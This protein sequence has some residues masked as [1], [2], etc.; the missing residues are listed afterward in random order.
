MFKSIYNQRYELLG[1]N[2]LCLR[3]YGIPLLGMLI[4]FAFCGYTFQQIQDTKYIIL[5]SS[6]LNVFLYWSI[7]RWSIIITRWKLN[8]PSQQLV[9]VFIQLFLGFG[10]AFL[11]A[12]IILL[13]LTPVFNHLQYFHDESILQIL[14]IPFFNCMFGAA[15]Y[16]GIYYFTRYKEAELRSKELEKSN[17]QAQLSMLKTQINPHFLFNSLNTLSYLVDEDTEK[18]Q[19]FIVQLSNVYRNII[20]LSNQKLISVQKEMDFL[21]SFIY[22]IK[23]RFGNKIAINID[24]D[25]KKLA[26]MIIP[27]SL[28]MLI[29]NAIK[30]NVISAATPLVINIISD[31]KYLI[32]SNLIKLRTTVSHSTKIGLQNIENRYKLVSNESIII[33]KEN[34]NFT[35]KIP[36][37]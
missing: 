8:K 25:S 35:V 4:P 22:L 29:E 3:I 28:Q 14:L 32:C 5:F 24:I 7:I 27:L 36:L 37:L 16:E 34:G 31:D 21:D 18:S 15:L 11:I 19:E 12:S 2:D 33:T 13:C 1:F 6:V 20:E 10:V 17:S 30:H 9:R 23:A 26:A